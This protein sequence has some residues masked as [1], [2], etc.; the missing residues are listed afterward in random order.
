MCCGSV[1]LSLLL[2]FAACK[3]QQ[4]EQPAPS[5]AG[6]NPA[7]PP[8]VAARY[9]SS[10]ITDAQVDAAYEIMLL[11]RPEGRTSNPAEIASRRRALA[12][13]LAIEAALYERAR[14]A[15]TM[16][17]EE[18]VSAAEKQSRQQFPSEAEFQ[19]YIDAHKQTPEEF[20]EVIRRNLAIEKLIDR[21][22]LLKY[23]VSDQEVAAFYE[24][25]RALFAVPERWHVAEVF[26]ASD[27]DEKKALERIKSAQ[28][29]LA[30]GDAFGKV[31]AE[32]S[33]APSRERAGDIGF[34]RRGGRSFLGDEQIFALQAGQWTPPI[35]YPNGYRIFKCINRLPP[36]Q[37]T[38]DDPAVRRTCLT[39]IR[40][41]KIDE[42]VLSVRL[43]AKIQVF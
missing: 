7:R 30:A 13:G 22:V 9:G 37:T 19:A 31:V 1:L 24:K 17:T 40:K 33:M 42:Y 4:S 36:E 27:G 5:P 29:R 8:G 34:I 2:L 6:P 39:Q 15:G 26:V 14:Q 10:D 32:F 25:N 23:P 20:T 35:K 28:A 43:E 41:D 12:E 16:P 18:E 3:G 21:D 38:L 11:D